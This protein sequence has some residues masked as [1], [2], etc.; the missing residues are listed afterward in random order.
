MSAWRIGFGM[1]IVSVV[2]FCA[3]FRRNRQAI[4][5]SRMR[6]GTDGTEAGDGTQEGVGF[7][8]GTAEPVRLLRARRDRPP[9]L[10]RSRPEICRRR[11]D[12]SRSLPT[13][14]AA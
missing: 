3:A 7:P 6:E 13:A 12:R 2:I 11:G 4:S 10:P 1:A 9:R 5:V 8:A 14:E